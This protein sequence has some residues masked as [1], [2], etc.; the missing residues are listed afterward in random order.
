MQGV[1]MAPEDVAVL[2]TEDA[3]SQ[4]PTEIDG[5]D[6]V[7]RPPSASESRS[8][9]GA[10][11]A[12]LRALK[13]ELIK[14]MSASARWQERATSLEERLADAEQR[15][16][17]LAAAPAGAAAGA[18]P[19]A[20]DALAASEAPDAADAADVDDA[21][22]VPDAEDAEAAPAVEDARVDDELPPDQSASEPDAETPFTT[23]QANAARAL[24][25]VVLTPVLAPLTTELT[26]LRQENE[27]LVDQIGDL[28]EDRGRLTAELKFAQVQLQELQESQDRPAAGLTRRDVLFMVG[29]SV[30]IVGALMVGLLIA[31][32]AILSMQ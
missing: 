27:A 29:S 1:T 32:V 23:S 26:L 7:A 30:A 22:H 25:A 31:W 9:D 21:S 16:A 15:L 17:E 12:R 24:V 19:D 20:K 2:H 13:S 4:S 3:E 11:E 5:T 10:A 18:A 6:G 14:S 8:Q 28:R